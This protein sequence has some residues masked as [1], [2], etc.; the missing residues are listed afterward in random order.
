MPSRKGASRL[1]ATWEALQFAVKYEIGNLTIIIDSNRLQAMDFITNILDKKK[2][3]KIR[4]LKGFGLS[5][6]VCSGHDVAKLT[7][8]LKA[9]KGS[10]KNKPNVIIA[11][12][13]KGFGLKCM[14]NVP[15]FHFRI[16]DDRELSMGKS[17][18]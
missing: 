1:P 8:A 4:R 12:T 14:E 11:E 5:P 7:A 9:A 2:D 18:E 16:P 17:Y 10:S 6:V 15:K 3:D 13:I